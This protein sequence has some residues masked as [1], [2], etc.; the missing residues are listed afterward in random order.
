MSRFEVVFSERLV[1]F[2][3]ALIVGTVIAA[4]S[5]YALSSAL[6]VAGSNMPAHRMVAA[7]SRATV[8]SENQQFTDAKDLNRSV[9]SE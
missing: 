1:N 9:A 6:R 8:V 3:L 5:A 4:S 7:T 2:V